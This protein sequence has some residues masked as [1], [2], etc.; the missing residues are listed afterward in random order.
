MTTLDKI[1][2][3]LCSPAAYQYGDIFILPGFP[4]GIGESISIQASAGHH[5]KPRQN[6][7][8]RS[9][10]T[11]VE[12]YVGGTMLEGEFPDFEDGYGVAVC[13]PIEL[14]AYAIDKVYGGK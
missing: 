7:E 14:V 13:V 2:K 6:L 3:H 5:C 8:D 11:H 4:V 9:K 12:V 10:Y 1:R